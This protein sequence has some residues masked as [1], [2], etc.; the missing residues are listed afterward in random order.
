LATRRSATR[1][2]E[3]VD[4]AFVCFARNGVQATSV[5]EIVRE[6]GVAKG[7]FYLYFKTRD[8]LVTAVAERIVERIALEMGAAL[9]DPARSPVERICGIPTAMALV[10]PSSAEA[11]LVAVM[12]RPENGP[13]HERLTATITGALLP[14]VTAAVEDGIAQGVFAPQQARRAAAFVLATF[15][16]V[17]HLV[18]GPEDLGPVIEDVQRFVMRGLG[19]RAVAA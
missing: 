2:S 10:T 4:A 6:A 13:I 12:H 11:D 15:T 9:R 14:G 3:L 8:D 5:D 17:D 7:T 1:A 19:A 16:A 18:H